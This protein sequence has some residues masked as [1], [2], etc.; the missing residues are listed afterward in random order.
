MKMPR[1]LPFVL[2]A[3]ATFACSGKTVTTGPNET[4]PPSAPATEPTTV[5]DLGEVATNTDVPF[6][7]PPTALGFNITV[8]GLASDV[9]S[10]APFGIE[11]I[12][13]PSGRLVHSNYTP[14]G[15]NHDTSTIA[16]DA[17]ASVSVPQGEAVRPDLGGGWKLRVG[18]KGAPTR[19]G[20]L[21]V[22]VRIQVTEDGAFHGGTLDLHVHIPEGLKFGATLVDTATVGSSPELAKRVDRYF[23]VMKD[24]IGI[25]RGEV[26]YHLESASLASLDGIDAIVQ[27]FSVSDSKRNGLQEMHLLFTNAIKQD[28][29]E[30]AAGISPGVP[31]AAMIFGRG[32]SGIIISPDGH[33]DERVRIEAD[34]QT[35]VHETGHFIGLNHTTEFDG[36]LSDPL[37]DTPLCTTM[38]GSKTLSNLRLCPDRA[39]LMF[40]AATLPGEVAAL[41]PT[42]KRVYQG[43]PIFKLF[44][45]QAPAT[46]TLAETEVRFAADRYRKLSGRPLTP[47][48]EELASGFCGLVPIDANGIVARHGRDALVSAST[49]PDVSP[50]VRGRARLALRSLPRTP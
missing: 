22:R 46:R 35:M 23:E 18:F 3:L 30:I 38:D 31:G 10:D 29:E 5:I 43:S 9:D 8:E 50:I 11:R 48:E 37:S 39:N 1:F 20:R 44:R 32:V 27:G 2:A 7:I 47:V 17:I 26:V 45:S 15:G 12:V 6:D 14:A 13:D 25:D 49:D 21:H 19:R 33:T 40:A 16:F 28:G 41:S 24:L 42:Q 4:P 36:V 34:A